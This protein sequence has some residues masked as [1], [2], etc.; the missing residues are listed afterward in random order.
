M[1]ALSVSQTGNA[2]LDLTGPVVISELPGG[3]L[4]HDVGTCVTSGDF[5]DVPHTDQRGDA[6][7]ACAF[8]TPQLRG[9]SDSAPYLHDGSAATL[10]DVVTVML[11]AVAGPGQQPP[12]LLA[13]DRRALVEFLRSL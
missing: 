13:P 9:L 5:V 4:L 12:S 1:P 8:D 10:D 11:D 2:T 3:V 7:D 6:R